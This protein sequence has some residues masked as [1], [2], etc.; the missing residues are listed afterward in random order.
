M[1]RVVNVRPTSD[2]RVDIAIDVGQSGVRARIIGV[3]STH[4]IERPAI[5]G[6]FADTLYGLAAELA[7]SAPVGRLAIGATG[8]HGKAERFDASALVRRLRPVQ[9]IVADDGVTAHLGALYGR[10]GTVAAVGTGIVTVSR[11]VDG[12][13]HR[14]GGHGLAIDDRGSGA[15]IGRLAAQCAI[16][17]AEGVRTDAA[18][19]AE[20]C[21][22]HLG[23]LDELPWRAQQ[24]HWAPALA[25]MCAPLA[26]LA[27]SG[28]SVAAAIFA[29]AG[30]Q[31]GIRLA[32]AAVRAGLAAEP[33]ALTGGVAAALRHLEPGMRRVIPGGTAI[34]RATGDPLD[35]VVRLLDRSIALPGLPLVAHHGERGRGTTARATGVETREVMRGS[36]DAVL[37]GLIVSCQAPEGSPLRDSRTMAQMAASA[38][39][40]RARAVR[41]EGSADIAAVTARA[42][43]PVIG[44]RKA[45]R[46][47]SDVYITSTREDVDLI[48]AAGAVVVALDATSRRRPG[49]E[50]LVDLVAH[51]HDLGL[52]VM[53]DLAGVED[54]RF[55][56]DAGVDIVAT[57][58]IAPSAEDVRAGGP[59]LRAIDA[60]RTLD[61]GLPIIAEGRFATASDLAGAIRAGARSVVMGRA[62]TNVDALI[63]DAAS[64]MSALAGR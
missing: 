39:R 21:R 4:D 37:D 46:T 9:T 13:M 41:V 32:A 24:P 56:R 54:A 60:I 26:A 34:T 43:L 62:L 33:F 19:V 44:I 53:G 18:P 25:A 27:D 47:G 10:P 64:S 1:Y 63:A 29:D 38:E 30:E 31:I 57:T 49:G 51:A 61:L 48:H 40:H 2:E 58:L 36:I 7:S 15:W 55:A 5:E 22:V 52:A 3:G 12:R 23:E 28:D 42:R 14:V 17:Q 50:R 6:G 59:N 35:G 45:R 11:A 20:L 16:D 8:M